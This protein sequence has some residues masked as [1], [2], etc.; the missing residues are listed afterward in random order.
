MVGL[1][2]KYKADYLFN[3]GALDRSGFTT[4]DIKRWTRVVEWDTVHG[5]R[6]GLLE[7]EFLANATYCASLIFCLEEPCLNL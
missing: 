5:I 4:I 2:Y 3:R 1:I 6:T 7:K